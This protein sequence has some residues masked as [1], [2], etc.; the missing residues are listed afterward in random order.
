MLLD[1]AIVAAWLTT[2][3]LV[4][5]HEQGSLW[6][7]LGNPMASMEASLDAKEQWFGIYYQGQRIGFSSMTLSPQ[8]LNGVPGVSVRDQG[9]L[10]FNLLGTPQ[11][12]DVNA[13]AFIDADWRLQSFA[14]TLTT[15][16]YRMSWQG[17]R[18]GETLQLTVKTPQST[19]MKQ[20]QDPTGSAFVNG[21]SSWAAFHRLQVGQS[22][23][24]WVLNP[25]A[26]SPEPVYFTVRRREVLDGRDVLVVETDVAGM[27][28]TSW[29]TPQGEVLK[30]TSPLGWELRQEPQEEI[31]KDLRRLTLAQPALDLLATSAVP[32]DR[33]LEDP[34]RIKTLTVLVEGVTA[35]AFGVQRPWQRI[36]PPEGLSGYRRPPPQGPWCL[37]QL[38][39]PTQPVS[40]GLV[41][42]ASEEISRYQQPSFFVQSN[43]PR[44]LAKSAEIVGAR[45]EPWEQAT[46]IQQWVFSTMTKRL[47]VGLPS[48]LDVLATQT[49]DC[50]EHTVLFTALAR[51]RGLP[52]RMVAG[53]VYWQG[54]G[55]YHAWPEVWVGQWMPTDPTLGQV[56]ADATHL[57]LIEAENESLLAIGQFIG[58]VRLSVLEV[59][60]EEAADD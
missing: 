15:P 25:L 3:G 9:R 5:L 18:R 34:Q 38:S 33:T 30:E 40:G 20:L 1:G 50:H 47:T 41:P 44:I 19:A 12:L 57:G 23:K 46:A 7:G 31:L 55:Y 21:L 16:T 35:K 39:R 29:V 10:T 37:V 52:T 13:W 8:E 4:V 54:R 24:A 2:V 53:L 60:Y 45:T 43:D 17:E 6:G 26:L 42:V 22:G 36:L 14:A 58:K 27:T 11:R 32:I 59:V 56:V 49:G 51:S 28:T 48:A